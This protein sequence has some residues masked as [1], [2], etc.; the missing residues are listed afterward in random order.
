MLESL[1]IQELIRNKVL[2]P[3]E[4]DEVPMPSVKLL[5]DPTLCDD[6]LHSLFGGDRF[7]ALSP[8]IDSENIE[9]L[10][11][12]NLKQSLKLYLDRMKDN[13]K[14]SKNW[15]M[16]HAI[17]N[18]LPVYEESRVICLNVLKPLSQN[19]SLP[20]DVENPGFIFFAAASQVTNVGDE[21]LRADFREIILTVIKNLE[22]NESLKKNMEVRATLLDATLA[23]SYYPN[24]TE[25]SNKEFAAIIEK[26]SNEGQDFASSF[27]HAFEN[28]YW[29]LPLID[30]KS[31]HYLR[32]CQMLRN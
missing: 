30:G 18:D 11:S 16:V 23:L 6:K 12:E 28:T 8:I 1:S 27:G 29:N 4:N 9:I 32:L 19:S 17:A 2:R 24:D 22:T 21:K 3:N 5:F 13:P 15:V 14:E 26:I 25:K 31:W 20:K 10:K 7:E